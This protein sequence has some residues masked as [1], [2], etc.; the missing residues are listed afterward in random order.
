MVLSGWMS[1]PPVPMCAFR[2]SRWMINKL[3]GGSVDRLADESI[4]R[5]AVTSAGGLVGELVV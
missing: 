3:A 4:C 2:I 5:G 1:Q